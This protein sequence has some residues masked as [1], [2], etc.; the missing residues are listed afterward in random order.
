[1]ESA[2]KAEWGKLMS[3]NSLTPLAKW[4]FYQL[5]TKGAYSKLSTTKIESITYISKSTV[6]R[7]RRGEI[8]VQDPNKEGISDDTEDDHHQPKKNCYNARKCT[9]SVPQ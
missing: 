6:S 7:I 4:H 5:V 3:F 1:M 9:S 2:F 8:K